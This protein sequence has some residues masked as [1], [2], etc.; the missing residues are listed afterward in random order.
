MHKWILPLLISV[1]AALSLVTLSSIAP[2]FATRQMIFYIVAAIVFWSITQ[3]PMVRIFAMS[4]FAYGISV[5][6]LMVVLFLAD[7]TRNTERW[8]Q[9]GGLFAIQPSQFAI[10]LTALLITQFVATRA[11][12]TAASIATVLVLI[13]IPA[14][15]IFIAPNLSTTLIF[16]CSLAIT[17][18]FASLNRKLLFVLFTAGTFIS[19]IGWIFLLQPYQKQRIYSFMSPEASTSASYNAEQALIA[20]GSGELYGRGL[21]Q[22]VQSHL[23][24]LPERQ[25]DFIF[26]SL[27]EEFGFFG[28]M[29]VVLLYASILFVIIST[30]VKARAVAEQLYCLVIAMAFFL[31]TVINIGMNMGLVPITGVTLPFISYG[32]SSIL[33]FALGFGIIQRIILEA[34]PNSTLHIS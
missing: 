32:G 28:S 29:L 25:T 26:A 20:V 4:K 24:F 21:G 6:M 19:L 34:K 23:R 33:A 10:P 27:A 14:C 3:I 7:T 17:L 31:Q 30:A 2:D 13:G 15:L 9:V 5:V 11:T 1:C 18:Y 12:L 22:G 16:I 8:I